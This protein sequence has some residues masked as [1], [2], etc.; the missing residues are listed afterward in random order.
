M[1]DWGKV[2]AEVQPFFHRTGFTGFPG[3]TGLIGLIGEVSA[4]TRSQR[5]RPDQILNNGI[6]EADNIILG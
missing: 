3:R 5:E 2:K 1:R 4:Y 6:P